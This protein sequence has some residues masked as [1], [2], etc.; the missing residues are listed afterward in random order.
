MQ[1]DELDTIK[2]NVLGS[3]EEKMMYHFCTFFWGSAPLLHFSISINVASKQAGRHT[4][5]TNTQSCCTPNAGYAGFRSLY[6]THTY[7]KRT[8]QTR[9]A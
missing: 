9:E 3:E 4:S 6:M 8:S 1:N 7:C 5:N 2:E